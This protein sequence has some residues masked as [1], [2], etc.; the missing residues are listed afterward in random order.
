[1]S[2]GHDADFKKSQYKL[3]WT[4]SE[5]VQPSFEDMVENYSYAITVFDMWAVRLFDKDSSVRAIKWGANVDQTECIVTYW[6]MLGC[7]T[8]GSNVIHTTRTFIWE[9]NYNT[10]Q[11]NWNVRFPDARF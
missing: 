6:M 1:M 4:F 5:F 10:Q 3:K 8:K 11:I 2:N 9:Y 7:V